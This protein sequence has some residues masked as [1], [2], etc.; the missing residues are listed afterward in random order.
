MPT[1]SAKDQA[2]A[3]AIPVKIVPLGKLGKRIN[4]SLEVGCSGHFF[5]LFLSPL[6]REIT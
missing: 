2:R 4:L 6:C 3:I 5:D 1:I